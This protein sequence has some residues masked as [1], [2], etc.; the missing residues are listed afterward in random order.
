MSND[1]Q[2][3]YKNSL[4]RRKFI[5]TSTAMLA[6]GSIVTHP[7]SMASAGTPK[8]MGIALVGLGYYSSYILAPA[9]QH[10]QHCYLAG[11][12]TGTPSK[13]T[14]WAEKYQIKPGNIYNYDNF[15]SIVNNDEIDIVY[16]V[17]P[18]SM[19]KEYTIRA[20]RAGKHVICE[21]P[22]ALNVKECEEM[23]RECD[24]NN[25]K[26]SIGY[27]LHFEPYNQHIM[28]LGKARPYGD[29]KLIQAA[30][31]FRAKTRT[32]K[33]LDFWKLKKA[34]GGGPMMD[35]GV[36][37]IQAARYATQMEPVSVTAQTANTRPQM[38]REIPETTL[39]QLNFSGGTV[40]NISGSAS[41]FVSNLN[42]TAVKGN[43]QLSPFW[44]YSDIK[45]KSPQGE[46]NFPNVDQQVAQM[47]DMARSYRDNLTLR[48]PGEEGLRDMRVMDAIQK[49]IELG[50]KKVNIT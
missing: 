27:R 12:V 2:K 39:A 42:I 9:L 1:E 5:H 8:K 30:A 35:I 20:A 34:M 45:G 26:L 31:G 47:D 11:I 49:S 15:D 7:L 48:V 18:N 16:V 25:V 50:S 37:A 24:N 36:Y 21:K 44:T 4:S 3:K 22:M 28:Q 29:I 33:E 6:A 10:T 14:L 40:A 19:H 46:F 17:L 32:G 23:I 43:Y 41:A 38:Y 13:E